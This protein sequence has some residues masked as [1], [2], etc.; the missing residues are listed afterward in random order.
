MWRQTTSALR[1]L[2]AR[3]LDD[4]SAILAIDQKGDKQAEDMLRDIAAAGRTFILIDPR[5]PDT[6]RW[7]PISGD[8]GEIVARTVEPIK[9]SEECYSDM[10]R[11]YLG[12]IARVLHHAGAWPPSLPFLIDCC[13]LRRFPKLLKLASGDPELHRRVTEAGE[14]IESQEGR[15]ERAA[16]DRVHG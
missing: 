6:D 8:V 4:S 7:Q 1:I 15:K 12:V 9:A 14:W 2:A 10:L 5:A 3:A 16:G 11:L 13:Q